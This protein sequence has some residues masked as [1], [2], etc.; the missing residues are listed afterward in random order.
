MTGRRPGGGVPDETRVALEAAPGIAQ[1]ES[2][3]SAF[4]AVTTEGRWYT[5]GEPHTGGS[6]PNDVRAAL[7]LLAERLFEMRIAARLSPE[8]AASFSMQTLAL[9][10]PLASRLGIWQVKWELE[11]LSF[12]FTQPAVYKDIAKKLAER[13]VDREQYVSSVVERISAELSQANL[14]AE[15]T[16]RPKHIFSIWRKMQMKSLDFH[17]LFDV[18][19][20]RVLT[21]SVADC[22]A[23][24]GV[25]HGLWQ[26]VPHEFDDYI[27][28]PK[29]NRY[30]SLHT[31]V[32]GPRNRTVEVQIRTQTMHEHAERGVAAH[33]HYKEGGARG[34]AFEERLA[35]L[36]RALEWRDE[37]DEPDLALERLRNEPDDEFIYV[38]RTGCMCFCASNH[39]SIR[40]FLDNMHIVVW[41]FLLGW[42]ERTVSLDVRL[43][44][45]QTQILLF[46]CPYKLPDTLP[47][48]RPQLVVHLRRHQIKCKESV[49]PDF[50]YK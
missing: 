4:A 14:K 41:M 32:I 30:Q 21:H 29:P 48:F 15:V 10:A 43:R 49:A 6:I 34:S 33:W 45:G 28:N 2:T 5:W 20:V 35:W 3:W 16:G 46:T 25:V 40:A 22:Y 23:A 13:R 19:A 17:E 38:G 36:R 37:M 50:F 39:D 47:I 24:L 1:L 31:A 11:D 27:A 8:E 42:Q 44:N 9:F 18:R 12:R 7:I 26:H